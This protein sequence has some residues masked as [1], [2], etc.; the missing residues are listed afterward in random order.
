MND[1]LI[2]G[3]AG[4]LLVGCYLITPALALAAA[5]LLLI[6]VGLVR[7]RGQHGPG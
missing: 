6:A 1:L 7:I 3:G 5:G 4:C 2:V